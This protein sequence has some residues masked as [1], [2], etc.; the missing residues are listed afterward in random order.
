[1]L[2]YPKQF[3]PADTRIALGSPCNS[4]QSGDRWEL[5][6]TIMMSQLGEYMGVYDQ[7]AGTSETFSDICTDTILVMHVRI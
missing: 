2:A 7:F 3:I 5:L 6:E 4:A 1:M